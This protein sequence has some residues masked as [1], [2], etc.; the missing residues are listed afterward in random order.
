MNIV[1]WTK[2]YPDFSYEDGLVKLVGSGI[3]S[4]VSINLGKNYVELSADINYGLM[5]PV[6]TSVFYLVDSIGELSVPTRESSVPFVSTCPRVA[7]EY[8]RGK[9]RQPENCI[10]ES[11][12]KIEKDIED[13]KKGI[14]EYREYRAPNKI[15]FAP[16]KG[17]VNWSYNEGMDEWDVRDLSDG[18]NP[19]FGV[20]RAFLIY[21]PLCSDK[22]LPA[23]QI[24][25]INNAVRSRR[26]T[27][28]K[29]L[30][31]ESQENITMDLSNPL[32]TFEALCAYV[33]KAAMPAGTAPSWV[34]H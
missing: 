24:L 7:S 5:V 29:R 10:I 28:I 11:K 4:E 18:T 2:L 17:L 33:E 14:T 27:Q 8:F 19:E 15:T 9:T 25:C 16:R 23:E 21:S 20:D 3:Q 1:D 26:L 34:G 13:R 32:Q 12:A 22:I 30:S 6:S 31:T